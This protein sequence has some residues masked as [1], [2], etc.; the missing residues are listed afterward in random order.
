[1]KDVEQHQKDDGIIPMS[2]IPRGSM[3]ENFWKYIERVTGQRS[4]K[5][6]IWQ[7]SVLTLLSGLPTIWATILRE[8]IYREVMGSVGSSCFIEKNVRFQV[9]Q[10]F[11]F[12]KQGFHR[13]KQLS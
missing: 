7:G 10:R 11:F 2:I 3:R 4:L 5:K 8:K 6:Y 1:M 12:R 13:R 9:P